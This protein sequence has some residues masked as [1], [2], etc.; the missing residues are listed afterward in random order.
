MSS[1]S[2]S[3]NHPGTEDV[4]G[5][6]L[7]EGEPETGFMGSKEKPSS[8]SPIEGWR[9]MQDGAERGE[10][11]YRPTPALTNPMRALELG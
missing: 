7:G 6:V 8:G 3:P 10:A 5:Q 11:T 1:Y 4:V 2:V 9:R